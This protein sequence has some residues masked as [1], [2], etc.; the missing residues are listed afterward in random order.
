[1]LRIFTRSIRLKLAVLVSAAVLCAVLVA[2][3]ATGLQQT[4]RL[5][6]AKR[7][8]AHAIAAALAVTVAPTVA[9]RRTRETA[10]TLSAM[11][12]MPDVV[13][14]GVTDKKGKLI[15]EHGA[16]IVLDRRSTDTN[17]APGWFD[18]I[19]AI[20]AGTHLVETPIIHRGK[21]EGSLRLIADL[22]GLRNAFIDGL[23]TALLIG[24]LAALIGVGAALALQGTITRPIREL[25]HAMHE[26]GETKDFGRTVE[27]QSDDETGELVD[28]FNTMITEIRARDHALARHRD[29][30]ESTV[31]ERTRD[32]DQ[33][34]IT[35]EQANAAKSDFLST[36][37][38]EIRTP[39][40]GMLVM[41]EL[42]PPVSPHHASSATPTSSLNPAKACSRSSTTSSTSP[43]SKPAA[44]N[45]SA[46]PLTRARCLT[47]PFSSFP[48][49]P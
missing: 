24:L 45:W 1:M 43:R 23:V 44:S 35:A 48:S 32:L 2:S 26:I 9:N 42:L 16:G 3:I 21:P 37:S 46:F 14:V 36:M 13:Y 31:A 33:A 12:R 10:R 27:R 6:E 19:T 49:A 41:A 29:T 20:I 22:S 15:F 25:S 47:T 30:L 8:E 5:I 39:M 38:H 11:S 28:S 40:N 7:T 34:R 18:D 17:A 4:K